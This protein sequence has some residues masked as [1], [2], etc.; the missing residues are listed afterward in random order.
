MDKFLFILIL[1]VGALVVWSVERDYGPSR[2]EL[3]GTA[4]CVQDELGGVTEIE[5]TGAVYWYPDKMTIRPRVSINLYGGDD[6]E[7]Q[8]DLV[9]RTEHC[10]D[11]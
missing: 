1:V 2:D 5:D 6:I 11:D 7:G 3:I 10:I 4:Q 9:T 8:I